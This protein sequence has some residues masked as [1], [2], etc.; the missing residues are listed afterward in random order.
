M[1]AREVDPSWIDVH[2]QGEGGDAAVITDA[3]TR[4]V[5]TYY[6]ETLKKKKTKAL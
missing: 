3:D 6:F 4:D 1:D 2:K 5:D